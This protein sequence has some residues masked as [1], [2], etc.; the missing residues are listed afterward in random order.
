MTAYNDLLRS[1]ESR[2]FPAARKFSDLDN[3]LA[4][5]AL[6]EIE[7]LDGPSNCNRPIG[8]TRKKKSRSPPHERRGR[9]S[10]KV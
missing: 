4:L 6:P 8:I 2:V 7:Q 5:A 9:E 3:S 1:I 10:A